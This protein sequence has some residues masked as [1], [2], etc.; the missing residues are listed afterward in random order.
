MT[1]FNPGMILRYFTNDNTHY[2]GIILKN[3]KVLSVKVAGQKDKTIYDS[4]IHWLATLPG[5]VTVSDLDIQ[6]RVSAVKSN[7][8]KP[9]KKQTLKDIAPNY[10][11]LRFLFTYEMYNLQNSLLGNNNNRIKTRTYVKD[12]DGSLCP[13]KYNRLTQKLYS[14]HHNK[15]GS[16]LEEIGF[17]LDA[18]IYV[19]FTNYVSYESYTSFIKMNF[20]FT[21]NNYTSVYGSKIAFVANCNSLSKDKYNVVCE[22]LKT[23]GYSI[24]TLKS[25]FPRNDS[26][27]RNKAYKYLNDTIIIVIDG[28]NCLTIQN[29]NPFKLI[30]CA[31]NSNTF[32]EE[33]KLAL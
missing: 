9:Y 10:D 13:V 2:T 8:V 32:M 11:L 15:Y 27:F 5:S 12:K 26:I 20:P 1:E 30:Q 3:D 17:P 16:N 29:F 21:L 14:T 23:S 7:K 24:Y 28:Y 33:L 4:I 31:S 22:Y 6:E 19:S 18:D 25:N